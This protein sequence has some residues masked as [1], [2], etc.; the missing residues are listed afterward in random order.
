ME[1]G[2][3]GKVALV[4]GGSKGIGREVARQLAREGVCVVATA[5]GEEALVQAVD[6]IEASGGRAAAVVADMTRKEDVERAVAIALS[7]FGRIDIAVSNVYPTHTK[8]FDTTADDDF[9]REFDRLVMS[10]I[11]LT[12]AVLPDMKTRGSGR[13]INIG[14]LAMKGPVRGIPFILSDI[15]RPGVAGFHKGLSYEVGKLGIT[16]NNIAVG[17]TKTDRFKESF[18]RRTDSNGLGWQELEAKAA[19]E[20]QIPVGRLG[21]PEE[22]GSLAVYLASERAAYIT[23]QTIVIDGGKTGGLF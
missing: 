8:G 4:S 22:V 2:L 1:L 17:F 19:H 5:R 3:D 14:S 15:M 23:G 20:L 21:S 11:Y 7:T 12:R 13:L 9:R 16:V 6:E 18:Q 10:V